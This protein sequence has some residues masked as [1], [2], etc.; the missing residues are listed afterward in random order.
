MGTKFLV[1]AL[2][3][4][5]GDDIDE[6]RV[7]EKLQRFLDELHFTK[8]EGSCV[9]GE[10]GPVLGKPDVEDSSA[11]IKFATDFSRCPDYALDVYLELIPF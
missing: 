1:L 8:S 2:N 4:Q 9:I 10:C 3:V 5:D 11:I 6:L 7:V